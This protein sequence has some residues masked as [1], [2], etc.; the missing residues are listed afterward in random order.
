MAIYVT[1]APVLLSPEPLLRPPSSSALGPILGTLAP[2]TELLRGHRTRPPPPSSSP[3]PVP[4]P[5]PPLPRTLAL[6]AELLRAGPHPRNPSA[7][8]RAPP[9][10][11]HAPP[12]PILL[13][14][15]HAL[16]PSSSPQNPCS[17]AHQAPPCWAPS[18]EP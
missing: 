12:R 15:V 4:R 18:P 6:P 2:A 9:R 7:V 1:P 13:P 8:H 5:C 14:C 10:P 3:V 16:P 11:P 17:S